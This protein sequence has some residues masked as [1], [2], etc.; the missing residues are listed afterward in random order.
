MEKSHGCGLVALG[1]GRH[2]GTSWALMNPNESQFSRKVP[3]KK[4]NPA[5]AENKDCSQMETGAVVGHG[6]IKGKNWEKMQN[7]HEAGEKLVELLARHQAEDKAQIF[8]AI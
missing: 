8:C 7:L 1:A 4:K 2:T 5:V 6:L 3:K